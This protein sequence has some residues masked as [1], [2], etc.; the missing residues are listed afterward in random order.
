MVVTVQGLG[1]LDAK[2]AAE[3][4]AFMAS[5]ARGDDDLQRSLDQTERFTRS[6]LWVLGAYEP[7]RSIA[8][9]CRYNPS[10]VGAQV[11]SSIA[12]AKTYFERIR[13]P[14]AKYE[15]A[16]KFSATD[17]TVAFPAIDPTKGSAW[18]V[19]KGTVISREDLAVCLREVLSAL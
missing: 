8:Q 18:I 15:P 5:R 4:A 19:G 7:I 14:L 16:R 2:L 13:V 11:A 3:D 17:S 9:K 10:L 1:Q 12:D 6:Y